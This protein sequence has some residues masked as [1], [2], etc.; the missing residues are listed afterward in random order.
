MEPQAEIFLLADLDVVRFVVYISSYHIPPEVM[1]ITPHEAHD[2]FVTITIR[3][4]MITQQH[5]RSCNFM[6]QCS[7]QEKP[8]IQ[9]CSP[10]PPPVPTQN[11]CPRKA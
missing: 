1:G 3:Y 7:R 4:S 9:Q 6:A 8:Q 5:P 11:F 2:V 10:V